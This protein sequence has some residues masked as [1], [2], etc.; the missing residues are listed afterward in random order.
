MQA[1]ASCAI[2]KI[3]TPRVYHPMNAP[4]KRLPPD[5]ETGEMPRIDQDSP[6]AKESPQP[7]TL[8]EFEDVGSS[9]GIITIITEG[10][11]GAKEADDSATSSRSDA[12]RRR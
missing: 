10:Q 1:P 7:R 4:K 11:D 2:T 12:R 8:P 9:T 5:G 6:A 3:S